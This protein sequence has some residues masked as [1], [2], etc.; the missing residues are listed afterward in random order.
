[1]VVM[2]EVVVEVMVVVVVIRE[3][4]STSIR[5]WP[6]IC[7]VEKADLQ[8]TGILWPLKCA[9]PSPGDS[10]ILT[11]SGDWLSGR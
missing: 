8:L 1:M 7:C 6:G 3:R 2:V 11:E 5:G 10:Y 4:V 9:L